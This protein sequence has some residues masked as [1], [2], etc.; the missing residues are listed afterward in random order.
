[1]A[2]SWGSVNALLQRKASEIHPVA[3]SGLPVAL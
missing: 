2:E 1:M 3:N